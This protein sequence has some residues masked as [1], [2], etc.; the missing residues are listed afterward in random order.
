MNLRILSGRKKGELL[1]NITY[2]DFKES[3]STVNL[4][5]VLESLYGNVDKFNVF[6]CMERSDHFKIAVKI[7]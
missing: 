3:Q 2:C 6:P 1:G 4:S 5:F 7:S